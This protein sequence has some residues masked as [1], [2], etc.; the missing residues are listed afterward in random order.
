MGDPE[1]CDY[2]DFIISPGRHEKFFSAFLDEIEKQ[3]IK[4][5]DLGTVR[6]DS[7]TVLYL[8]RTAEDRARDEQ[9]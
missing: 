5:L 1:V 9:G 3:K 4:E 2:Q 8:M 7:S 6:P